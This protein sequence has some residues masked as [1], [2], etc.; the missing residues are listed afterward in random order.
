MPELHAR[1]ES[2]AQADNRPK[3]GVGLDGK[4]VRL[5]LRQRHLP[6]AD[7]LRLGTRTRRDYLQRGETEGRIIG[8]DA[9][10]LGEQSFT[11]SL[12]TLRVTATSLGTIITVTTKA[13]GPSNFCGY[14]RAADAAAAF[15]T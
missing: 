10:N 1:L 15:S 2:N 7:V 5:C 6:S 14:C 13:S 12:R 9:G 4:T 8:A 11:L 3:C